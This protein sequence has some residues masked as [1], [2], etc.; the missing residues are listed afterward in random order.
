MTAPTPTPS[1]IP[2]KSEPFITGGLLVGLVLIAGGFFFLYM[3]MHEGVK[4][5]HSTHIYVFTG[6]IGLGSLAI[7]PKLLVSAI[8]GVVDAVAPVL[9]KI[10]FGRRKE[11]TAESPVQREPA[12]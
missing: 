7:A 10:N 3:E 11:D 4:D 2:Q 1:P 5:A 12:P 9:P 8:R 6:M